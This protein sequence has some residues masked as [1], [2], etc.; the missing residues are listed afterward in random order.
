MFTSNLLLLVLLAAGRFTSTT[1]FQTLSAIKSRSSSFLG[2]SDMLLQARKTKTLA[3][4][5]PF[6]VQDLAVPAAVASTALV[7]LMSE[8]ALAAGFSQ[9]AMDP[10]SFQPVCPASDGFYRLLQSLT[11]GVV[12]RESF[13]EYGPLIAGGLLRIRLELCVVESFANEAVLPFVRDN[14]VSWIL[15]LHETVET[16]IAGV[17]FALATTFILLGSTKLL[18]VIITYTD[19]LVGMPSRFFAG[20]A[21]DRTTGKPVTLDIGFGFFKRRVIGPSDDDET[22][23]PTNLSDLPVPQLATALA[24]GAVRSVGQAIGVS[25]LFVCLSTQLDQCSLNQV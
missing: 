18:T 19:F 4:F 7:S 16:F 9:G 12:G 14:G 24:F 22:T 3:E 25:D 11:E 10:A 21:Y 15:P 1:A 23:T 20:F 6:K 13:L 2:S 17:I 5:D 8:Q